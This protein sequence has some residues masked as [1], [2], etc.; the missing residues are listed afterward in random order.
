[1]PGYGPFLL[2]DFHVHT[3]RSD[4]RHPLSDVA[5]AGMKRGYEYLAITDHS[6]SLT[7]A[8]G[9]SPQ[10]VGQAVD[11]A[12]DVVARPI[13]IPADLALDVAKHP[14][15]RRNREGNFPRDALQ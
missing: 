6:P 15:T 12:S 10:R 5:A 11:Q 3:N 9:L 1:M 8:N 2:C 4:G 13:A 7:V 14:K